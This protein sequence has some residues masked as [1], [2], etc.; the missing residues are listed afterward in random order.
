MA[1]L[2]IDFSNIARSCWHPAQAAED[3]GKNA[4]VEHAKTCPVFQEAELHG[5]DCCGYAPKQ[6]N[7][8]EVFK[9][10]LKL[11]IQTIQEHTGEAPSARWVWAVDSHCQWRRD[12]VPQY[13]ANRDK[14][15]FDPRP[16]GLRFLAS[17]F[18]ETHWAIA[19]GAEADDVI[20]TLV[21]KRGDQ[22]VVIV[23]G[24]KDLWQ[25]LQ[26]G[27][28]V[29]LPTKKVFVTSEMFEDEFGCSPRHIPLYK[30]FWGDTSD[31]LPN[32][33]P[34]QQKAILPFIRSS[35]GTPGTVLLRL[36]ESSISPK[37]REALLRTKDQVAAN[38]LCAQLDPA[39]KVIFD[40][41]P[42][43]G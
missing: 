41:L 37:L 32:L 18:P 30:A 2:F 38:H 24:D 40:R 5:A 29:F 15:S 26:P 33:L 20:A 16:E 22:D 43:G 39:V 34:R 4:L 21:A 31:N 11:K 28:K 35:D 1:L 25:L 17:E 8:H 7:A 36:L 13:K 12:A 10:N 9:T 19:L 14:T 42:L 6:Y 27:V 3:A 23:S